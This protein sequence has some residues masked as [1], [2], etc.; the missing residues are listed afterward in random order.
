MVETWGTV[1]AE[2]VTAKCYCVTFG[3]ISDAPSP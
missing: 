3:A 1:T 2:N